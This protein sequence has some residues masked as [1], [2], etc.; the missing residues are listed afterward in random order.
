M[1]LGAGV[2]HFQYTYNFME[3]ETTMNEIPAQDLEN[4]HGMRR[5]VECSG[6]GE[7]AP[8]VWGVTGGMNGSTL[9]CA[10]CHKLAVKIGLDLAVEQ[11]CQGRK[12]RK[13]TRPKSQLFEKNLCPG[14]EELRM[15]NIERELALLREA[16]R[17]SVATVAEAVKVFEDF[18]RAMRKVNNL[19]DKRKARRY[20]RRYQR[21]S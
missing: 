20:R 17:K 7:W 11:I 10:G 18:G 1:W 12:L 15:A 3:V 13:P 16:A 5:L 6:C 9:L 2:V 4:E 19:M 8:V 14:T 21:G